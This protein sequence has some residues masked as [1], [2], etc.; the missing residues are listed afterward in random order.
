MKNHFVSIIRP[1]ATQGP[2]YGPFDYD[3]A[4]KALIY[5][6]N[7]GIGGVEQTTV[8]GEELS[9]IQG[10]GSFPTDD[11]GGVFIVQSVEQPV[12]ESE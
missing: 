2:I 4:E 8:A 10:A 7:N 3:E 11:G 12:L 6:L 9:Y 5:I 1:D